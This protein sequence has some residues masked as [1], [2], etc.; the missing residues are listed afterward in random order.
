MRQL[1]QS[2]G[3]CPQHLCA[4]WVYASP[5]P[6]RVDIS[7]QG[8]AQQRAQIPWILN[9]IQNQ[10]EVQL[11]WD[12]GQS[13]QGAQAGNAIRCDCCESSPQHLICDDPQSRLDTTFSQGRMTLPPGFS[14]D[15]F[16]GCVALPENFLQQVGALEKQQP[17]GL[18]PST[19]G[20]GS[21]PF[22]QGITSA[23]DQG[24]RG[25]QRTTQNAACLRTFRPL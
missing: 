18:S 7:G 13:I 6:N 15:D 3:R 12:G 11:W 4:K 25:I 5:H 1:K 22:D 9:P 8:R 23:A 17:L 14:R 21:Q 20:K 2:T 10:E 24:E 19:G 16:N